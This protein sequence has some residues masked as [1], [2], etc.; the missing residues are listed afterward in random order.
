VSRFVDRA[1]TYRLSLGAC[2]CP[3][4]PHDEDWI[5]LR[6]QFSGIE[7]REMIAFGTKHALSIMVTDWN[8]RNEGGDIPLTPETL[9]DLDTAT[10]EAI[11]QWF[12]VNVPIPD[13]PNRSGAH[14]RN[15]S[16][17]SASSARPK[18]R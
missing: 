8:L 11:D 4:K 12:E 18:S 7:W 14:S 1:A 16:R 3:D 5:D 15:G 10:C 13:F 9:A 6:T 2:Q 17:V